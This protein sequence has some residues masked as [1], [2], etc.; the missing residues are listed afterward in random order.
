[1]PTRKAEAEWKGTLKEGT[2]TVKTQSG[3]VNGNYSFPS[4][5][6][7]GKGTNPEELVAA[8]HAAC[9]SM[10]FSY[11]LEKA[12]HK[13]TRVHTTATVHLNKAAEGFEINQIDLVCEA[14]VP[15][16]DKATFDKEAE[17]AKQNCPISK[18]YKGAQ[19]NLQATLKQAQHA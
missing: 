8:A 4:R 16:L 12:G 19:I 3:A 15:G 14:E 5:F 7:E 1:M 2:G 9:Y 13:A 11:G 18:L 17:S 6:E 10:A